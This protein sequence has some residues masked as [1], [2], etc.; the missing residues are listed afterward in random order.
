MKLYRLL[1]IA[2][3][4]FLFTAT[5]TMIWYRHVYTLERYVIPASFAVENG[6]AGIT[7]D[8]DALRFGTMPPAGT[9]R[10]R[11]VITPAHD[12]RLAITIEGNGSLYL[13]PN[14]NNIAL[15]EGNQTTILFT[16]ALP[17]NMTLGNY[18][19]DVTFTFYRN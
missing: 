2:A 13:Y 11:M 17:A 19:A 1:A 6:V 16:A 4:V 9:S 8:T 15:K 10:R 5:F 3:I 7:T 14:K 12:S 18:T